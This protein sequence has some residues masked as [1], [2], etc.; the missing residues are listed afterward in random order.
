MA[1]D[2]VKDMEA[3]ENRREVFDRLERESR[4]LLAFGV[5]RL[6]L[7]GSFVRQEPNRESDV[8]VLVDFAAGSKTFDNFMG[9]A[10]FLEEILKRRVELVTTESLSPY[11]RPSIL[12]EARDVSLVA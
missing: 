11:L 8:D 5:R 4:R 6:R 12:G 7:F 10:E 2:N 9:L 1:S 3:V